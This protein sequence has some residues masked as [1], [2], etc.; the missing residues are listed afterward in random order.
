MQPAG[1][2]SEDWRYGVGVSTDDS[3][4]REGESADDVGKFGDEVDVFLCYAGKLD[5]VLHRPFL[6]GVG[7]DKGSKLHLG[8][9]T[10]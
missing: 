6:I 4:R 3:R 8:R 1:S 10:Q 7:V 2:D 9:F 5:N